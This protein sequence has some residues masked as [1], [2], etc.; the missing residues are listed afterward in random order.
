[1]KLLHVFSTFKPAGPQL[2]FLALAE[3]WGDRFEHVVVAMDSNYDAATQAP[4][5]VRLKLI[6]FD[7]RKGYAALNI[8]AILG[9]LWRE[10]PDLVLTYN[11][12]AIEW[13]M[14]YPLHWR[15][16]IHIEDGFGSDEIETRLQRRNKARKLIF[17]YGIKKLIV[18]SEKLKSI[19]Q[20]E[21]GVNHK[22]LSFIRN[23]VDTGKFS[24]S[25][26]LLEAR[27]SENRTS[28]IVMTV[29]GLRPEK[30]VDRLIEAMNIAAQHY[31]KIEKTKLTLWIVGDGPLR[32]SLQKQAINYGGVF[33]TIFL[34][35]RTDINELLRKADIYA[36]SSD[37][38]Q[39]P[40][41]ILEAMA[42]E[43]PVA[44]VNVGDVA[45]MVSAENNPLI[46]G[47]DA[48]ALAQNIRSL[49]ESQ[50]LRKSIASANRRKTV[51]QFDAKLSADNWM[52]LITKT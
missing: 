5:S 19:A 48:D 29:C 13:S 44:G 34:G 35:N 30:R 15:K 12:G 1:V 38:E 7:V 27:Y 18:V 49:L 20:N 36:I 16:V 33:D 50:P 21:W 17:R 37:T 51:T 4:R 11:W 14:L 46:D 43:L 28:L 40:I 6:E 52:S 32:E 23:G 41:S 24:T 10:K 26:E 3:R 2:R 47:N 22:K 45:N 9:V 31:A 42:S 39:A 8:Q 25:Q